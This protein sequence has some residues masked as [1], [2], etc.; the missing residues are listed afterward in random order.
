MSRLDVYVEFKRFLSIKLE[1]REVRVGRSADCDIQLLSEKVSRHHTTITPT[2][3][4]GFAIEDMST[5]GTRVNSEMVHDRKVLAP[6]DRIY[7]DTYVLVFQADDVP[8][9]TGEVERTDVVDA[10]TLM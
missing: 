9:D 7:I 6:G 10:A 4:G 8:Q 1:N 3:D 2:A 5:N